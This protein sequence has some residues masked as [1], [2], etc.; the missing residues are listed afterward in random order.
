MVPSFVWSN[1]SR[2]FTE[3]TNYSF[4]LWHPPERYGI[5]VQEFHEKRMSFLWWTFSIRLST[6]SR[7]LS[8][9]IRTQRC[10][11]EKA[12]KILLRLIPLLNDVV[13]NRIVFSFS[14][15]VQKVLLYPNYHQRLLL[16][17]SAVDIFESS[18]IRKQKGEP[19]LTNELGG[20]E[21][22]SVQNSSGLKIQTCSGAR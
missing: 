17:I 12:N 3:S 2:R 5:Y 18:L 8:N 22:G 13:S 20:D 16:A 15:L 21:I 11:K 7:R 4:P 14:Q 1:T 6:S 10:V 19:N 9:Q